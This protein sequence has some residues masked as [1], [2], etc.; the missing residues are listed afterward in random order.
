MC[1]LSSRNKKSIG[2]TLSIYEASPA[3]NREKYLTNYNPKDS[4]GDIHQLFYKWLIY[5]IN[6]DSLPVAADVL[7]DSLDLILSWI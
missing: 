4:A 7:G 6:D 3:L 1:L 2:Y 5:L